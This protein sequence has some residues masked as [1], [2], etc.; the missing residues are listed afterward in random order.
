MFKVYKSLGWFFKKEWKRYLIM[1]ILLTILSII[2]VIPANLLGRAIDMI[3]SGNFN[4]GDLIL[5]VSLIA[6]IPLFS[7]VVNITYHYLINAEGHKLTFEL[8]HNYLEHLFRLDAKNYEQFTKGELISRV[9]SDMNAITNAATGLLQTMVYNTGVIVFTI[10]VMFFTISWKLTLITV[11]IM[12]ISITILTIIRNKK[13]KY[14]KIHS[15]IYSEMQEKVLETIEG[16]R[17]LRAYTQEENDYEKVKDKINRDIDS[18]VKILR[19]E[20]LFAPLFEFIYA[21][22]YFL[23]FAF[24]TYYVINSKLSVGS[25]VTFTMYVGTLFGPITALGNIIGS[26]NNS[27]IA[28]ERYQEVMSLSPEV[29]DEKDSKHIFTFNKIEFKHVSFKYP[30]DK[31]K[32]IDDINFE[33]NYGETIG[34]VGPT[35]A[36]KS[37]LIR[38]LLREFNVT[39]GNIL[40]DNIPIK[41]YLVEDVRN[42]VGY[43]PQSYVLFK[44]SVDE[45]IIIGNANATNENIERALIV[46]DFKKDLQY[47][48]QGLN[49]MVGEFGSTLSGGQR[50]R[51]SIAR[52]IVKDPQILILDDS[53]SAVDGNTEQT[54]LQ[55][56][57]ETRKGKTNII[58]AHRFSAIKHADKIIVLEN[59]KI[60]Q[61]GKHE[62]LLSQDGW[63]KEQYIRQTSMKE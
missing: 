18:W 47:M 9:T 33:I 26:I 10:G 49:T 34:V 60:T 61:Q 27:I 44:R 29:I 2:P 59:G 38:Q 6:G 20:A 13:R 58:V 31:Y 4:R 42:L 54:I 12:P 28:N 11:L 8:R 16:T 3:V 30:F 40:I 32:V 39:E 51:L 17:T 24:G 48:S 14:Y 55:N 36:G 56:L 45:N 25:L 37:T 35:G 21:L 43:V 50:Q 52:A 62:E 57:K 5:L 1:A 7:Y 63:Y 22:C 46:S 15:V 53:L 23:A 19:F 41:N